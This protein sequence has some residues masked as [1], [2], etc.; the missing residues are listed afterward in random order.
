[1]NRR[2]EAGSYQPPGGKHQHETHQPEFEA[3]PAS[4][5]LVFKLEVPAAHHCPQHNR[6]V[7]HHPHQ[8]GANS[9]LLLLQQLFQYADELVPVPFSGFERG[10]DHL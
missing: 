2:L 8:S 5:D 9:E 4:L 1:M 10:F 3:R 6:I 7:S